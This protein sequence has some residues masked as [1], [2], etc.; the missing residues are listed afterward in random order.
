MLRYFSWIT[1]SNV[2]CNV[3][4]SNFPSLHI[5]VALYSASQKS[6]H[7][8]TS[9]RYFHLCWTCVTK[10]FSWLLHSHIRTCLVVYQ[11]WSTCLN[12]YMN[13]ITFTSKTPQILTIQFSLIWNSQAF[14]LITNHFV[15]LNKYNCLYL[16]HKL[17]YFF[18]NMP[19]I[20]CRS[21]SRC[22]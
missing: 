6:S 3:L 8:K 20:S 10:W 15:T 11:F 13:Y 12:I 17:S 14:S 18:P 5:K 16:L 4:S 9:L 7:P 21:L 1:H 19:A 22:C 2:Y